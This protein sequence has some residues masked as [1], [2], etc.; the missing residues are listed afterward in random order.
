M[1]THL[2]SV[3]VAVV[4]VLLPC[5]RAISVEVSD[6]S[7]GRRLNSISSS[8]A[9]ETK[10]VVQVLASASLVRRDATATVS[11]DDHS[12]NVAGATPSRNSLLKRRSLPI[13]PGH[14]ALPTM[15]ELTYGGTSGAGTM[16]FSCTQVF[17]KARNLTQ[18]YMATR[19]EANAADASVQAP[20]GWVY[21]LEQEILA[22]T[23]SAKM[24]T[25]FD[26]ILDNEDL[27]DGLK[28][29]VVWTITDAT[30]WADCNSNHSTIEPSGT[31]VLEVHTTINGSP[32]EQGDEMPASGLADSSM[33]VEATMTHSRAVK[34]IWKKKEVPYCF[35]SSIS[36]DAKNA[37]EAAVLHISEQV[38]CLKFKP[39]STRGGANKFGQTVQENCAEMPSIIV[40]SSQAGCWSLVGQIS[41]VSQYKDSS[42]PINIGKG[43]GDVGIAAHEIGHAIGMLHEMSRNDRDKWVNIKKGN[44]PDSMYRN[45]QNNT[46]ADQSTDFDFLSLMMYGSYAFS[47]NGELTIV[48]HDKRL[49]NFMGQRM[50]FSELDIELIGDLYGCKNK[51]TPKTRNKH[52]S[53]AY[54]SAQGIDTGFKG[55]CVDATKTGYVKKDDTPM[56]CPDLRRYCSHATLGKEIRALCPVSCYMCQTN[57]DS[58]ETPLPAPAPAPANTAAASHSETKPKTVNYNGA[59]DGGK[60]SGFRNALL[61]SLVAF[62]AS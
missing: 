52:L 31:D 19:R 10:S 24:V 7:A 59:G 6:T 44:I 50:G 54:L 8:P 26:K 47:T 20:A 39:V 62:L 41:H 61:A 34:N 35:A 9:P 58:K 29:G 51:V 12:G 28:I 13:V 45:F 53:K 42:Q 25:E 49:V 16:T 5:G 32:L 23:K 38:P 22:Q 36:T 15:V 4:A 17:E 3:T 60:S 56:S 1:V 27:S 30:V 18:A 21:K 11:D 33:L 2:L 14:V 46:A 43:C 40:Q 37:F 48:P 55:K 57:L